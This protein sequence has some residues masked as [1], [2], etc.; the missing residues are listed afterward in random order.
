MSQEVLKYFLTA[1]LFPGA[2]SMIMR[3]QAT[4]RAGRGCLPQSVEERPADRGPPGKR[5]H[6]Q[7]ISLKKL[8]ALESPKWKKRGVPFPTRKSCDE[9]ANVSRGAVSRICYLLYMFI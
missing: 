9:N 4:G 2:V 7:G 3:F 1:L 6:C 8:G 5:A